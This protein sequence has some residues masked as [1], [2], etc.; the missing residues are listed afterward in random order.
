MKTLN[1]FFS[2]IYCINLDK[3]VDRYEES[4][5]EFKKIISNFDDEIFNS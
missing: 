5:I 1:E 2:K 4:L 3:R